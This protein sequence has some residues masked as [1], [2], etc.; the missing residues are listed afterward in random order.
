MAF[1]AVLET[2][3]ITIVYIQNGENVTNTLHAKL[4]GGY[5]LADLTSLADTVDSLV[6]TWLLP[7]MTAQATYLRT[8][9][10]GLAVEN[11][12]FAEDG[13]NSGPGLDESC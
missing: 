1:Q 2:V 6:N 10:R 5:V 13:T 7:E 9:V 3:E 4:P 12:L 8:E 11:D